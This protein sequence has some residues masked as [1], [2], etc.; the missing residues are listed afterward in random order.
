MVAAH[1]LGT[2]P[3]CAGASC[4]PW[5]AGSLSRPSV[6]CTAGSMWS[7]CLAA[8]TEKAQV[9]VCVTI[10]L[11]PG[12]WFSSSPLP[13]CLAHLQDVAVDP[14]LVLATSATHLVK[15]LARPSPALI[16]QLCSSRTRMSCC[17]SQPVTE[18]GSQPNQCDVDQHSTGKQAH[19]MMPKMMLTGKTAREAVQSR[20]LSPGSCLELW[21]QHGRVRNPPW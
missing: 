4:V 14:G 8:V 5:W 11:L 21:K 20:Q 13:V 18:C 10:K 17:A 16:K 1:L 19:W 15:E 3:T 6:W 7:G 12:K 2:A 9:S